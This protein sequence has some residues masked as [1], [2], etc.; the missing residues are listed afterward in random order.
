MKK[1]KK[2][3]VVAC[4]WHYS[5]HFYEELINQQK[6]KN[7]DIDYFIV[8]HR[9]PIHSHNEKQIN[10]NSDDL[11]Q[12]L[13]SVL[14]EKLPTIESLEELGWNYFES[15]TNGTTWTAANTWLENN[16]YSEYDCVLFTGDDILILRDDLF[17]NALE[18]SN[19][20]IYENVER[21]G[22]W[23]I[24]QTKN[25]DNWLVLSNGMEA[26]RRVSLRA[27]FEFFKKVLDKMGGNFNLNSIDLNRDGITTSPTNHEELSGWNNHLYTFVDFLTDNNLYNKLKFLSVDYRVSDFI[28]DAERGLLSNH[29]VLAN[30][31][32]SAID[33]LNKNQVFNKF[34]LSRQQ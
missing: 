8:S 4:G 7:W 5:S 21:N 14:Y 33:K 16:N 11:L 10:T 19:L 27:S 1:N 2:L 29:R 6:P 12:F 9:N 28:V 22:S 30:S 31:Y 25:N 15:K 32:V 20:P 13:N 3:A 26:G 23:I 18:N 34:I 17:V 24:E